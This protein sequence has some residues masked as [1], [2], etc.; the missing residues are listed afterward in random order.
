MEDAH[1]HDKK[2]DKAAERILDRDSNLVGVMGIRVVRLKVVSINQSQSWSDRELRQCL[3]VVNEEWRVL[4]KFG[5]L[6]LLYK[7]LVVRVDR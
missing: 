1:E 6:T 4:L 5:L 3:G 2:K 7:Y